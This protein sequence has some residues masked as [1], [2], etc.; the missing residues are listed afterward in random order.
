MCNLLWTQ[1]QV[2][3]CG[4]YCGQSGTGQFF[5]KYF[6]FSCQFSSHQLLHNHPHIHSGLGGQCTKWTQFHPTPRNYEEECSIVLEVVRKTIKISDRVAVSQVR[7]E[8]VTWLQVRIISNL[9]KHTWAQ[10]LLHR[11]NSNARNMHAVTIR[12]MTCIYRVSH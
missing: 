5:S 1:P 12:N 11:G 6:G 10:C 8:L 7:F 3:S 2:R 9:R 4:I